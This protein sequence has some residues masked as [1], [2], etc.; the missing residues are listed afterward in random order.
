MS[1]PKFLAPYLASYDLDKLNT[2]SNGV[3]REIISEILN[4]G[5]SPAIKW[6]FQQYKTD[7]IRAVLVNPN[8]GSWNIESLNYWQKI[9]SINISS[10]KIKRA[11]IDFPI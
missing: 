11:I 9:F 6:L 8:R 2:N 10:N 7:E 4:L 1:I 5:S 3:K